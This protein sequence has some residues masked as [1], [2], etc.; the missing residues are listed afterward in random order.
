MPGTGQTARN[1]HSTDGKAFVPRTDPALAAVGLHLPLG[2]YAKKCVLDGSR[3]IVA[4]GGQG[5]PRPLGGH[6]SQLA[7]RA[8]GLPLQERRRAHQRHGD[9]L[10]CRG[11]TSCSGLRKDDF[12][13]YEDDQPVRRSPLQRRARPG[14]PGHR[15]RHERQHGGDKIEA[16]R[17]RARP[18]PRTTCSTPDDEIFLYRFSDAPV[19]LQGVDDRSPA[20]CRAH[21]VGI[22]ADRRHGDVRRRR[23]GDSAGRRGPPSTRRRCSSSRTATTRRAARRI[24]EPKQLIRESEV[25]VYAIGIDGGS[26]ATTSDVPRPRPRPMPI[27]FPRGRGGRLS[28]SPAA[29][30][31]VAGSR[32]RRRLAPVAVARQRAA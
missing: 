24:R 5:S 13:V 27:P 1:V 12:T 31:Q 28:R 29:C 2:Q 6:R 32:R 19:L 7:R 3:T 14:E 10:R 16:A 15:S 26:S 23:R 9:G 4:A 20:L 18:L 17:A 8:G 21:S 30:P 25:L 22:D 11:P